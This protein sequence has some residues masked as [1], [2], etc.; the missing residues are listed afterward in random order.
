[1]FYPCVLLEMNPDEL[2][3]SSLP[4]AAAWRVEII[5][6]QESAAADGHINVGHIVSRPRS[7]KTLR[8]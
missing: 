4:V 1:M 7:M 3:K 5:V 8:T 6:V 2:S